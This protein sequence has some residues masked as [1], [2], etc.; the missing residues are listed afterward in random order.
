[1]EYSR[2]K[3]QELA[4][5][6]TYQYLFYLITLLFYYPLCL[7]LQCKIFLSSYDWLLSKP[8]N[9]EH[10]NLNGE[11]MQIMWSDSLSI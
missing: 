2:N 8:G 5:I 10:E 6:C 11:V 1:M 4:M 3:L 9:V 7:L